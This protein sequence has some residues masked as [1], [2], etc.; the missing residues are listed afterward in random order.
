VVHEKRHTNFSLVDIVAKPFKERIV[1][2]EAGEH[3]V[4]GAEDIREEWLSK[5]SAVGVTAGASAPESLVQGVIER[6]RQAGGVS[7]EEVSGIPE[8]MEFALPR[9]LRLTLK[10]SS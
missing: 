6:L 9:D 3:L 2:V 1:V 4:D 10:S 5:I 8:T 7:T